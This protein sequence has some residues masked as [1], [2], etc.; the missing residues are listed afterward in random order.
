LPQRHVVPK[1]HAHNRSIF[2]K[3]TKT[4]AAAVLI[5]SLS[6]GSG[7]A[8]V[9]QPAPSS[10]GSDSNGGFLIAAIIV[11]GAAIF[12]GSRAATDTSATTTDE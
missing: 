9:L 5:G 11:I 4:L 6:L 10:G 7:N 8:G 2:M 1:V 12:A 3:L